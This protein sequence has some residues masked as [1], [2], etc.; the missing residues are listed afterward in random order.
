MQTNT[1]KTPLP[2]KIV[3]DWVDN[4]RLI[5]KLNQLIDY[6]AELTEVVNELIQ[7]TSAQ[8][9]ENVSQP[10]TLKEALLD[11]LNELWFKDEFH[12]DNVEAII[13]RLMP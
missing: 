6:I 1:M 3:A 9:E 10:P 5:E 12:I 11:K 2:E 8:N 7:P 4:E 13:N